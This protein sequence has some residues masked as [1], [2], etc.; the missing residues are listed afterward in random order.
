MA[1]RREVGSG[2]RE[3]LNSERHP[4]LISHTLKGT[5]SSTWSFLASVEKSRRSASEFSPTPCTQICMRAV[6]KVPSHLI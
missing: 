4:L 1:G 2:L 5:A 6:G 3:R